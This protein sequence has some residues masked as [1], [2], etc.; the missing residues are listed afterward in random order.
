MTI[1]EIHYYADTLFSRY[2][3]PIKSFV[4]L[5]SRYLLSVYYGPGI[6]E[7][8]ANVTADFSPPG[9]YFLLEQPCKRQANK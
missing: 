8:L 5:F 9:V 7:V 6:G 3:S 1:V 4:C 2:V